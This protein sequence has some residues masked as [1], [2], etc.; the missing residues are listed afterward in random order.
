MKEQFRIGLVSAFPPSKVTINEYGYYLTK[1]F[2]NNINV[3]KIYLYSDYTLDSKQLDFEN[4]D[5]IED[6]PCW[7]FNSYSSLFRVLKQVRNTNPD[8]VIIN[9]HFLKFGD[10]KIPAAL[11]LMLGFFIRLIGK[12][13]IFLIHN[14][15]EKVDLDKAGFT[16]NPILNFIYN[17]IG[18][19]LTRFILGSNLVTVTIDQYVNILE[20]KY[21]SKNIAMIP[22]GTFEEAPLPRFETIHPVKKIMTFGK[23][24]TY[25]K[26]EQMIEAVEL[27]RKRTPYE[28]EIVIAG[29][30]SPN[31]PGYLE[32]VKKEYS[33]VRNII[34]TGYVPEA[35]VEKYFNESTVVV[36]PYTSTTGSSG[37]LHQAGNY[38]KAVIMPMIDDFV[39]LIEDEGYRGAYFE[40]ESIESLAQAIEKIV[41]ND[42]FRFELEKTNYNAAMALP[43]KDIVRWY[44]FHI[45]EILG[46]KKSLTAPFSKTISISKLTNI[47]YRE[48]TMEIE[49]EIE[50][51][52]HLMLNLEE[53]TDI[54]LAGFNALIH[55]KTYANERNI[56][57][58]F[59][60]NAWTKLNKWNQLTKMSKNF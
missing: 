14:I 23:F 55:S 19:T 43:M 45:Q 47:N 35:D 13:S 42:T 54:D 34:F 9:A 1:H 60:N 57:L 37:V 49:S 26:V 51:G 32:Q 46:K 33:H 24:G 44:I 41:S 7:N 17:L 22:H 18:N 56:A 59:S 21:K 40:P 10:K 28:Y 16:S 5:K 30:D 31:T 48:I 6:I 29:T 25:K 4:S 11:G 2:A 15:M 27:L 38:G 12:K 50:K 52:I 58:Y 20:A 3:E 53:L 8:I 36:F 39:N